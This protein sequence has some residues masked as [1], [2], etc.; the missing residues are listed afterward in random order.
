MDSSGTSHSSKTDRI[1]SAMARQN[2]GGYSFRLV[3]FHPP[4]SSLPT[5]W[6]IGNSFLVLYICKKRS[7][8][9]RFTQ[10]N[11]VGFGVREPSR[12]CAKRNLQTPGI[13]S[14]T[15]T[16]GSRQIEA[17]SGRS[18]VRRGAL[19]VLHYLLTLLQGVLPTKNRG[20][21]FL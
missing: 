1:A 10:S 12:P 7:I 9:G 17:A 14:K 8:E 2:A 19:L 18:W 16:I 11:S 13:C 5:A 3:V 15:C 6:P 4:R 21:R 20:A